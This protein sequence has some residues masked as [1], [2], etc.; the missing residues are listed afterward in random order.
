MQLCDKPSAVTVTCTTRATYI[1]HFTTGAAPK[2]Y[3]R[4]QIAVAGGPLHSGWNCALSLAGGK[5]LITGLQRLKPLTW[6]CKVLGV[7][8]YCKMPSSKSDRSARATRSGP[9]PKSGFTRAQTT[10]LQRLCHTGH[11]CSSPNDLQVARRLATSVPASTPAARTDSFRNN[12]AFR[13]EKPVY[14]SYG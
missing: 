6:A 12:R 10:C 2:S 7:A 9:D 3:C 5:P 8:A 13:V 11:F 14:G 4:L 1:L